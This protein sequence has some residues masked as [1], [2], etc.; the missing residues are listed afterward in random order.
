M[1]EHNAEAL[2]NELARIAATGFAIELIDSEKDE[3][4]Y[5]DIVQFVTFLK[6]REVYSAKFPAYYKNYSRIALDWYLYSII[7]SDSTNSMDHRGPNMS[8]PFINFYRSSHI[9]NYALSAWTPTVYAR[10]LRGV[11]FEQAGNQNSGATLRLVDGVYPRDDFGE[12]IY[13]PNPRDL[14]M[15]HFR[16]ENRQMSINTPNTVFAGYAFIDRTENKAGIMSGDR[17]DMLAG[18]RITF[19]I[20]YGTNWNFEHNEAVTVTTDRF[21]FYT[22]TLDNL[23]FR[24]RNSMLNNNRSAELRASVTL[25]ARRFRISTQFTFDTPGLNNMGEYNRMFRSS[26][27]AG[28]GVVS[29]PNEQRGFVLIRNVGMFRD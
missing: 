7:G 24:E 23:Y 21:G 28:D 10:A 18:V 11:I 27:T 1:T 8:R 6:Y 17:R 5:E 12:Y 29:L 19:T 15:T 22:I 25:P 9:A 2:T 16:T 4:D 20:R 3:K 14:I 26:L 13:D